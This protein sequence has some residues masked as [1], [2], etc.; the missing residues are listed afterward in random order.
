[1]RGA[2]ESG[3]NLGF[4]IYRIIEDGGQIHYVTPF[5]HDQIEAVVTNK[6]GFNDGGESRFND[7]PIESQDPQES[8]EN[9]DNRVGSARFLLVSPGELDE[10]IWAVRDALWS[11]LPLV[12]Y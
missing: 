11:I 3:P 10:N 6:T 2:V 7:K 5:C 1:M 8:L 9:L 4:V 12:E